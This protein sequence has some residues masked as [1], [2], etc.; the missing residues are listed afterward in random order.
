MAKFEL[1]SKT[2]PSMM[3]NLKIKGG[4]KLAGSAN[5]EVVHKEKNQKPVDEQMFA[6]DMMQ[7]LDY[8]LNRVENS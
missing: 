6:A 5:V 3:Y 4:A 2:I 1:D 8:T 7:Y